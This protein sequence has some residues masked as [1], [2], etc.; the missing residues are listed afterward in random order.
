M[1]RRVCGGRPG[2]SGWTLAV[3]LSMLPP[4][5]GFLCSLPPSLPPTP[6]T[7]PVPLLSVWDA[8]RG[9]VRGLRGLGVSGGGVS[10]A[11]PARP[12][13]LPVV[14]RPL[15]AV[16][17]PLHPRPGGRGDVVGWHGPLQPCFPPTLRRSLP[18]RAGHHTHLSIPA[19]PV[20]ST[21]KARQ[22]APHD[23]SSWEGHV[24]LFIQ[25]GWHSQS[26]VPLPFSE[27][28]AQPGGCATPALEEEAICFWNHRSPR[29][30]RHIPDCP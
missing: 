18:S 22:P 24:S 11:R 2:V 16:R 20:G 7:P 8:E 28:V 23:A 25:R 10:R 19:S 13:A 5:A 17:R 29:Y 30:M 26:G 12:A 1:G 3:T 27:V 6:A 21:E 9:G 4:S 14:W 15:L